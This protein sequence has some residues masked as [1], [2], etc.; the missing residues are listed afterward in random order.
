MS[1]VVLSLTAFF[2]LLL[3]STILADAEFD[4]F[5]FYKNCD[6][7]PQHQ[8][9]ILKAGGGSLPDYHRVKCY[10]N[11]GYNTQ[12]YTYTTGWYYISVVGLG[13]TECEASSLEY[14]Y[15]IAGETQHVDLTVY[16]PQE[17]PTGPEGGE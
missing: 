13:E 10:G 7:P 8:V 15:H 16:G 3:S 17:Q 1:K 6:C 11:P 2:I 14:V 12:P 4:G 5:V 9:K